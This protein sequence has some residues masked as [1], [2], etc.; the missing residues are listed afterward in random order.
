M[1]YSPHIVVLAS[2]FVF[3][4]VP[5]AEALDVVYVVRHAQKNRSL[6]WGSF[7]ALR[8]LTPKGA[9]C[10]GQLGRIMRNR[11]IAAVYASEVVRALATG[12]AVSTT[13]DGVEVIGDDATLKPTAELVE[14]LH[15]RHSE[16]QAI[17][18]VGHSNTVDDLVL[19][20]RPDLEDCL[21]RYK[22]ARPGIPDTQYGDVWRLK[23]DA[24]Q[25]EC[26]G[27]NRQKLGRLGEYDCTVP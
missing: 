7:D 13:H 24:E 22:L 8:P 17:L 18:I 9:M 23:L 10:A 19:A 25:A 15:E 5:A 1:R 14:E 6:Q 12:V 11:G 26:G 20:F 4:A 21:E 2:C 16:D 3:A 27:V